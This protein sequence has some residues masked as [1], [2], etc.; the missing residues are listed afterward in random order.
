LGAAVGIGL[1]ARAAGRSRTGSAS[2][3]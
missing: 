3:M 2:G 1:M